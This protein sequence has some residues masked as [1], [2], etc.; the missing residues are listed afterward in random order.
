MA[1]QALCHGLQIHGN[2]V[3]QIAYNAL[4]TG[5]LWLLHTNIFDKLD[6]SKTSTL[7]DAFK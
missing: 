1:Y 5:S 3:I 2:E 7:N 6:I 4:Y